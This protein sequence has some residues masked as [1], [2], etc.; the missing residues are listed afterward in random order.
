MMNDAVLHLV[1]VPSNKLSY[2]HVLPCSPCYLLA[3]TAAAPLSVFACD[4]PL[5]YT[6]S[7]VNC[8]ELY[9]AFEMTR[10]CVAFP[11]VLFH[12]S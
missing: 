7:A 6:S 11:N 12:G 4:V 3:D 9:P 5:S 1:D 2:Q 10:V 8:D